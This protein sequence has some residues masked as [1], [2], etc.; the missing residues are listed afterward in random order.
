M[1]PLRTVRLLTAAAMVA[2]VATLTLAPGRLAWEI[3]SVGLEMIDGLPAVW[4]TPFFAAG[5]ETALN[6]A[7]FL[8]IGAALAAL[9]PLRWSPLAVA[10]GCALSLAV[11]TAQV[12]VPGRVPDLDDVVANTV[13]TALG[14]LLVV[15][16]RV[17]AR[18]GRRLAER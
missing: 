15:L 4:T 9:L 7:L 1:T 17:T 11:E 8:P 16:F 3:R 13:G 6:I 18:V 10:L 12:H 5:T 14:A 2:V